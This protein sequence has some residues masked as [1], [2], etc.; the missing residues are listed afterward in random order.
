MVPWEMGIPHQLSGAHSSPLSLE[1]LPMALQ[2][3]HIQIVRD[4]MSVVY[5]IKNRVAQCLPGF[6]NVLWCSG[7]GVLL[8]VSTWLLFMYWGSRIHKQLFWV[9]HSLRSTNGLWISSCPGLSVLWSSHLRCLRYH[10]QH[11]VPKFFNHGSPAQGSCGHALLHWWKWGTLLRVSIFSSIT[12]TLQKI[13][14]QIIPAAF[15]W[16]PDDWDNLGY[17]L[18]KPIS[19][20]LPKACFGVRFSFPESQPEFVQ[21]Y[22]PGN[23]SFSFAP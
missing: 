3:Q 23:I 10:W 5:Y 18:P 6:A 22:S 1:N 13:L 21:T 19:K 12:F 16:H 17:D 15:L 4:N 20:D 7:T 11:K 9:S 14:S 2:G 8:K